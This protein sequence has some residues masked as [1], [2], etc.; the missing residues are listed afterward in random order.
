M[1]L[2]S[3]FSRLDRWAG[4]FNDWFG[5]TAQLGEERDSGIKRFHHDADVVHPLKRHAAII[6]DRKDR[7]CRQG[8]WDQRPYL[9][10]DQC[11]GV[12]P[13]GLVVDRRPAATHLRD[14]LGQRP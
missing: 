8:T 4:R 11:A 14:Y 2:M 10:L 3:F 13:G 9:W 7:P 5:A 1:G 12:S 6:T